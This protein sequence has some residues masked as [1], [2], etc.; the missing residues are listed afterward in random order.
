VIVQQAQSQPE[1]VTTASATTRASQASPAQPGVPAPDTAEEVSLPPDAGEDEWYRQQIR[2]D[3]VL[4]GGV[5]LAVWMSGVVLELHHLGLAS[6]R[7]GPWDTYCD[8][9]DLLRASARIDVIAGTS[10]GGLNGAFF[11]LGQIHRTSSA[12]LA[13]GPAATHP[14]CRRQ[15]HHR[16]HATNLGINNLSPGRRSRGRLASPSLVE[17]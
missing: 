5:S 4:N 10:A 2:V 7:R 12:H 14:G 17:K 9:L 3:V 15:R 16:A 1:P 8:V 11:A 13:I 6:Q